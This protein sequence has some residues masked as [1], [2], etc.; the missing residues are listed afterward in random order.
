MILSHPLRLQCML[1]ES[2]ESISL[3]SV[4]SMHGGCFKDQNLGVKG[5]HTLTVETASETEASIRSIAIQHDDGSSSRPGDGPLASL[6][7]T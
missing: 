1:D 2:V 7:S 6:A 3:I 5:V 4:G